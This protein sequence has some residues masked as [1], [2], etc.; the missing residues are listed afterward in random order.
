MKPAEFRSLLEAETAQAG[1]HLEAAQID[2][3]AA[4]YQLICKWNRAVRL[5]GDTD[6]AR[7]IGRHILESLQLIPLIPDKRGS[8]LDIGSGNGYPAIPVKCAL[9]MLRVGMLEPT[10]RKGVFLR[11][12]V[13]ELGLSDCEVIRGRVDAPGDLARL[14]R[15]DCITMRAVAAIPA[16]LKGGGAVLRAG[17]RILLMVGESGRDLAVRSIE[18]PL[19][20][21]GVERPSMDRASY[22]VVAGRP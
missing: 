1:L 4:H 10:I 18:A 20:L 13:A 2:G 8:L 12:V 5:I 9:P 6:P 14:G 21:I 16:V 15:W 11:A 19:A 22:I 3:I 17:G 7:A